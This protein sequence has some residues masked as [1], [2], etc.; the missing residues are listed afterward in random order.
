MTNI[1][2]YLAVLLTILITAYGQIVIKWQ[3][4]Q[5]NDFS[6]SDF[7]RKVLLLSGLLINPWVISALIAAVIASLSWMA[8]MTKLDLSQAYPLTALN[9]VIVSIGGIIF[10]NEIITINRFIG[11]GFII[12]GLLLLGR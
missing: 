12:L 11:I 2:A 1:Q 4:L 6:G 8:A 9:L 7:S 3:V 10:F 5:I